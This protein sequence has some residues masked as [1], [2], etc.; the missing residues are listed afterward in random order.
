MAADRGNL[1]A[2]PPTTVPQS[3]SGEQDPKR[4]K[5]IMQAENINSAK[6]D[7]QAQDELKMAGP[8]EGRRRAQ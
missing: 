6:S 8:G 2:L 7:M 4:A 5:V 1:L 3:P